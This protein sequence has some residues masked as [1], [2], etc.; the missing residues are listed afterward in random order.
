MGAGERECDVKKSILLMST[1]VALTL[2]A[3]A[4][5]DLIAHYNFDSDLTDSS[6]NGHDLTA[7]GNAAATGA[8]AAFG[9]GSLALDGT[10]DYAWSS[11]SSF[12]FGTNNFSVSFWYRFNGAAANATFVGR[13]SSSDNVGFHVRRDGTVVQGLLLD[14]TSLA[15]TNAQPASQTIFNHLVFQRDSGVLQLF[16]NG[17]QA[18]GTGFSNADVSS[19]NFAFSV[20][21]RNIGT[22]GVAS[23]GVVYLNGSIDELW[24]F[25]DALGQDEVSS[26]YSANVVPEPS[27]MILLGLGLA[28]AL[29]GRAR[30]AI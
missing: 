21:A 27:T 16:V 8:Q 24:V 3:A 18:A 13:G 5:A 28:G 9:A 22:G 4:Y 6:G 29:M 30:R 1:A 12:N 23:N 20:G 10:G 11:A 25:N 26:L 15:A 2:G 14:N 7:A 19:A 17:V